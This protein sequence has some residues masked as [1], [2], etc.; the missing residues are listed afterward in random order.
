MF[1]D[2]L[3]R[4]TLFTRPA[5]TVDDYVHKLNNT[6]RQLLDKVAPTWT[7]CCHPQKQISKWLSAEAVDAKLARRRLE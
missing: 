6:L 4:S 7:R 2:E 3:R 1:K 5:D